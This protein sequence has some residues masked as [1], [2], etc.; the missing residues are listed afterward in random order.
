MILSQGITPLFL[1][2][3]L[4]AIERSAK[5][6]M[7]RRIEED[8]RDVF[9]E[10]CVMSVPF[11]VCVRVCVCVLGFVYCVRMRERVKL[12]KRVVLNLEEK[13]GKVFARFLSFVC[14]RI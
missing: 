6:K 2:V 8:E 1:A 3:A 9:L 13:R 7:K 14:W 4:I 12:M 5:E 11:V 10:R